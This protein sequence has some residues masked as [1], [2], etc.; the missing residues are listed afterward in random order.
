MKL[1][2]HRT[3]R[4]WRASNLLTHSNGLTR[5]LCKRGGLVLDNMKSRRM[6]PGLNWHKIGYGD[7]SF[8]KVL[9][10]EI[11]EF[12]SHKPLNKAPTEEINLNN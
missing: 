11:I 9:N 7:E 8:V 10:V 3:E 2:Y 4:C 12:A 5:P 1:H 6:W